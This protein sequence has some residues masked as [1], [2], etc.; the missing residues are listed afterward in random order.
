MGKVKNG[1]LG[2]LTRKMKN[3]NLFGVFFVSTALL[4]S[5]CHRKPAID[6]AIPDNIQRPAGADHWGSWFRRAAS[7]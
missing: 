3:L 7:R 5:G 6:H 2:Q 1:F 4:A